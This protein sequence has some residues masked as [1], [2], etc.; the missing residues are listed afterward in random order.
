M[1]LGGIW[2]ELLD[3]VAIVPLPA[4]AVRIE[5]ALR[6]LRGLPVLLPPLVKEADLAP[7]LDK[8]DGVML[9]GGDDLDPKKMNLSP[10]PSVKVVPERR[11]LADRLLCKLVQQRR[12][13]AKR[14]RVT[15]RRH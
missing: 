6:S 14:S 1:G 11:E 7:I 8:L 2:T 13:L 10:H 15:G 12:K 5:A 3:D 9:T 4:S